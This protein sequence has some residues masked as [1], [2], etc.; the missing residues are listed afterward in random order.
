MSQRKGAAATMDPYEFPYAKKEAPKSTLTSIRL[1][2]YNPETNTYFGRTPLNWSSIILFYTIFYI[3]LA[4]MFAICM[5]GLLASVSKDRPTYTLES[6]II[7]VNPGL[8]YRPYLPDVDKSGSLIWYQAS[9]PGN[10]Q[11]WTHLLDEFL[12]DYSEASKRK[13]GQNQVVCSFGQPAPKG[14]VCDVPLDS[15]GPC[16]K[17]HGYSYNQSAPCVFIKLNRIF[18]W[19]PEVYDDPND[20]P[21]GMDD[22]LKA[23]INS[24]LPEERN[25]IWVSCNGENVVDHETIGPIDYY[26]KRGFPAFYYPYTNTPGY[27]SPLVAVH[28]RR[29]QKSIMI[30]IECRAWAKNIKV[31]KYLFNREGSV[32]FEMLVD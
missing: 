27:L 30:N 2:I 8:G 29:P 10:T 20:L 31:Q 16:S 32:H 22:D 5:Y 15:F 6:S 19:V 11:I 21:E 1:A 7:G 12:E 9:D 3:I 13:T 23:A 14:K 18:D 17:E 24:S 25:M 28:F 4:A 26:P